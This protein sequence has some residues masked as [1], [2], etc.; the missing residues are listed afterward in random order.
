MNFLKYLNK[1]FTVINAVDPATLDLALSWVRAAAEKYDTNLERREWVVAILQNRG[2][3]E[4]TAR[5]A[6]E[7]ACQLQKDELARN[8]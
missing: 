7:L 2:I 5:L 1:L 4:S 6:V 3:P 8:K